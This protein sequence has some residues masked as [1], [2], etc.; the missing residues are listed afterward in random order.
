LKSVREEMERRKQ[1]GQADAFEALSSMSAN[2]PAAYHA[3]GGLAGMP[4]GTINLVC[5]NVPGPLIPLY[6]VGHRL[7]A[8]YPLVPLAGDLGLGV[9]ITS[10]DK[11]LYVGFMADPEIIDDVDLIARYFAEEFGALRAAA[12]VPESDLPEIGVQLLN[13][14]GVK[15]APTPSPARKA[16]PRKRSTRAT[17]AAR[18]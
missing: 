14:N 7:L 5:T 15:P 4:Q 3:L 12:G 18:R 6:T 9:G 13:G 16:A 10:F 17:K 11:G 1:Q 2:I 8:H